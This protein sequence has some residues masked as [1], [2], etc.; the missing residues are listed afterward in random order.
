MTQGTLGEQTFLQEVEAAGEVWVVKGS[1]ENIFALQLQEAGYSLPVWSGRDRVMDFL[2]NER[3]FFPEYEP[4]A[5]PLGV[6]NDKLL[7]DKMLGIYD[8]LINFD[9]REQQVLVLTVEEFIF[10]QVLMKLAS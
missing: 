7:L 2:L 3:L 5:V 4:G 1:D 9:G 6:F 8:L 10:T